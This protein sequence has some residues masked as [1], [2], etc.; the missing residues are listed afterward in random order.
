MEKTG[1]F[2]LFLKE[3]FSNWISGLSGGLSV[4]L[5]VATLVFPQ[6]FAGNQGLL[7]SQS[8][9]W[10]ASAVAFMFASFSTWRREHQARIAL[11]GNS[12]RPQL[13]VTVKDPQAG[14]PYQ[15]KAMYFALH[16]LGGD[17][18]KFIQVQPLISRVNPAR[19]ITFR[20]EEH[21]SELQSLRH[22][23]CR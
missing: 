6:F 17:S 1:G 5:T 16:H 23:V 2:F 8:L 21:T 12:N 4:V 20:S 14:T 9:Y 3:M 13:L 18:A 19:K 7:H 11:E 15:G 10:A 22:L